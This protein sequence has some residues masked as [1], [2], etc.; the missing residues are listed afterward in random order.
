MRVRPTDLFQTRAWHTEQGMVDAHE[1]LPHD[2]H[3]GGVLHELVRLIDGP[4]LRV[5]ER[6]HTELCLTARD[7]GEHES[8]SLAGKR[9][10]PREYRADSALAVCARFPLVGDVHGRR[11]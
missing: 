5:L 2:P 11:A 6:N 1:R 9:L 3:Q 7:A 8:D 4:S 10:R